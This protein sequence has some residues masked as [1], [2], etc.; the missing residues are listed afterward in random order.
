M[1]TTLTTG[2]DRLSPNPTPLD[3]LKVNCVKYAF[4]G[5]KYWSYTRT[6]PININIV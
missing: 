4:S 2:M 5:V 1:E 3:T 6:K